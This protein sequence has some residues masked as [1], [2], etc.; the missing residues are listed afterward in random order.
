MFLI[1]RQYLGGRACTRYWQAGFAQPTP[2]NAG[3]TQAQA[4]LGGEGHGAQVFARIVQVEQVL[5]EL[6]TKACQPVEVGHIWQ[7]G[8]AKQGRLPILPVLQGN[9]QLSDT[10]SIF[11]RE[12]SELHRVLS[13]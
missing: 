7:A 6:I 1:V 3:L 5:R 9:R 8:L 13:E 10:L 2:G 4:W 11:A 12:L